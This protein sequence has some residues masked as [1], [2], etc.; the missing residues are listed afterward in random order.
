MCNEAWQ[1][2]QSREKGKQLMLKSVSKHFNYCKHVKESTGQDEY[3]EWRNEEF[4]ERME[5][6]T[7]EWK[8]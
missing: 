2:S 3:I 4:L 7:T 1:C 6:L 8:S 5:T